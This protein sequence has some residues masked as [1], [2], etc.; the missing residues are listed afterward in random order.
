MPQD[1]AILEDESPQEQQPTLGKS[2]STD[3]GVRSKTGS[4]SDSPPLPSS[5]E[6]SGDS[7]LASSPAHSSHA[8]YKQGL[9]LAAALQSKIGQ[10]NVYCDGPDR[11]IDTPRVMTWVADEA[12]KLRSANTEPLNEPPVSVMTTLRD[13]A[14]K[15]PNHRALAWKAD[16]KSEYKYWTYKE[17]L[18]DVETAAKAFIKVGLE[19]AHGVGI[20]GFNSPHWFISDLGAIFAGGLATGVYTTN[21]AEACHYVLDNCSAN[22]CVVENDVQLQKIFKVRSRLPHLKAIIQYIGQPKE[23][24]PNVYSWEE[25]MALA[26]QVSDE[27]LEARIKAQAPN[28]CCTLIYTSGTT[29]NSKGVMLSHDNHI[30]TAKVCVRDARLTFGDEHVISYLPLSHIAAQELDI[31]APIIS[32]GTV[33][34]ALPDAMKGSLGKTMKEVRPTYFLG[35]PRVWEKIMEKM[36]Q[37]G[38]GVKG[39][40]KSMMAWSKDVGY[41]GSIAKMN[42]TSMPFGHSLAN[43]LLFKNVKAALGLDRCHIAISGAAPIMKETLDFFMSFDLPIYE[44]YGMSESS[45]P[46]TLSLPWKFRVGTV[47]PDMPGATTKLDN[48]DAG[49]NGEV[50]MGGRHVFMGY[51]NMEE[52]TREAIDK[53]GWLHSGDIGRKDSD[54][55]LYITGRIKELIITAGGENIPPV[56][57]EDAIKE[58]LP[59]VSNAM[60]IGDKRKFLSVLLT[61]KTQVDGEVPT[62]QLSPPSIDWCRKQ[63]SSATCLADILDRRDDAVLKGIQ[64]GIDRANKRATSRAQCIQKWSI[65]PRD[66]SVIGGELG[67][68]LK[69]KRPAVLQ[70]YEKTVESFYAEGGD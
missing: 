35:V 44:I 10:Q 3:S 11:V 23:K 38:K 24:Y 47:G 59:C 7:T 46:H 27:Q 28:K 45:G 32:G 16:A 64:E 40:K 14:R 62:S 56:L 26:N 69:L 33:Y 18:A 1:H 2:L 4:G 13:T 48:P 42:A 53:D 21:N 34:F 67:P 9:D 20:L 65:L 5:V 70:M 43:K 30:W 41:R 31:Y 61:L 25:F 66:F 60:L 39:I 17:Y 50:C 12:V 36:V 15:L 49:G 55:F 29:G 51:L 68:T 54:G 19:P 52:K 22:V 6:S 57:I 58:E 37:S 8:L 63:G